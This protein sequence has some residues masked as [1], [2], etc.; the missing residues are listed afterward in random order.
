[1]MELLSPA[2]DLEKL[3]I[4]YAYGADAAYVGLGKFSLRARAINVHEAEIE[5]IK[6]I[7]GNRKLYGTINILFHEEDIQAL[8]SQLEVIAEY[9]FDAF[10][11]SDLGAAELLRHRFPEIRLHLSTQASC[12]NSRA[13]RAYKHL[14]FSRII[15][16]REA[17]L[18][19]IKRIRDAV[20]DIE[21]ETFVHGAMCM[22]YSGRC[23]LSAFMANRSANQGDCAHSCRW[24]YRIMQHS[25]NTESDEYQIALEEKQRPNEYFPIYEEDGYSTILSSKDLCMIDHLSELESAGVS[26]IKIEGRMKSLYYVATVTRAY[27]KALDTADWKPFRDELFHVSHR[28]FTTGFYYDHEASDVQTT[29]SY[30]RPYLFIGI[31]G[32]RRADGL[33]ALHL[34][35]SISHEKPIEFIGPDIVA[36]TDDAFELFDEALQPVNMLHHHQ[37]AFIR[38]SVPIQ[39]DYIVRRPRL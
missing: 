27:R 29:E 13:V 4:A 38:T 18:D 8:E 1:M 23:L 2:G 5:A 34:K 32:E 11:V 14:G 35:N 21:L 39:T 7:K 36:A 15:L 25:Q 19:D 20:D 12:L 16:G 6:K 37:K 26:S 17:S 10:I 28:E 22:A 9:P 24:D 31:V 3:R 30:I 33:F